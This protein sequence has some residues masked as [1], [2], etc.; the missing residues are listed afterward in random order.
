M[1]N[2]ILEHCR[3]NL[4]RFS[5]MTDVE[6]YNWMCDNFYTKDYGMVRKCSRI[7]FD[8]SRQNQISIC[9]FK[10][11]TKERRLERNFQMLFILKKWGVNM[12]VGD[13]KNYIF[14]E[15]VLYRENPEVDGEY[16]DIHKGFICTSPISILNLE[17]R[18]IGAKRKGV[19]DIKVK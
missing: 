10:Y 15:V 16:I 2:M 6:I 5:T 13:L 7:I 19:V 1:E 17:V 11:Q 9:K 8:E 3:N 12:R 14:D 4:T 18:T